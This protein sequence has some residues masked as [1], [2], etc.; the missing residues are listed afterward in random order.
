MNIFLSVLLSFLILLTYNISFYL[1]LP[2]LPLFGKTLICLQEG[3]KGTAI[4]MVT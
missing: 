1:A 2:I 4:V 3:E